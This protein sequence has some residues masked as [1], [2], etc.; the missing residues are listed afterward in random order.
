[1]DW[2]KFWEAV[3]KGLRLFSAIG[4][5]SIIVLSGVYISLHLA[6]Y[7]KTL[8]QFLFSISVV[9][10]IYLLLSYIND[11]LDDIFKKDG[12]NVGSNNAGKS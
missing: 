9:C 11:F 2:K 4:T 12:Q 6:P 10:P 5:T 8:A 1:M 3:D 7:G